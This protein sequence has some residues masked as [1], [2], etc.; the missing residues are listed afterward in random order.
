MHHRLLLIESRRLN[1]LHCLLLIIDDRLLYRLLLEV[2]DRLLRLMHCWLLRVGGG[3]LMRVH[4]RLLAKIHGR[5]LGGKCLALK[6]RTNQK[7]FFQW[8]FL[9]ITEDCLQ[10]GKHTSTRIAILFIKVIPSNT[11]AAIWMS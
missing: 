4:R 11:M 8:K 10:R 5:W 2:D 1:L 6:T 3:V 9:T 7:L